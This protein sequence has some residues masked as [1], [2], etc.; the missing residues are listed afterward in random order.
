MYFTVGLPK[1]HVSQAVSLHKL[2]EKG[3]G[4]CVK[5]LP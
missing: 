2:P 5:E 4:V 3:E 1:T